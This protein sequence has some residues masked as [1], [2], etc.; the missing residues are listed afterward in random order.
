MRAPTSI[1]LTIQTVNRVHW[2]YAMSRW[3]VE[4]EGERMDLEEFPKWFPSGDIHAVE[5]AGKF[6]ITGPALCGLPDTEAVL[7]KAVDSIDDYS[8]VISLLWPSLQKPTIANIVYVDPSG[9]RTSHVLASGRIIGRSKASGVATASGGAIAEAATT[10]GQELLLAAYKSKHLTEALKLWADPIRTWGRLYR[11]V[12]AVAQHF[13]KS[14]GDVYQAGVCSSGELDRFKATA[15]NAEAAGLDARHAAG[16][17]PPLKKT[18]MSLG[19]ATEF[20]RG[21]LNVALRK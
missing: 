5:E 4:L 14:V 7:K 10:Q 9:V 12:E 16:K 21:V 2:S 11:I 20:V 1:A 13:G 8:A 18:P 15:N 6:Y 19:E 3:L 17:F